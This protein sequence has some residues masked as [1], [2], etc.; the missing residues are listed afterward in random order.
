MT[1]V[2]KEIGDKLD[3][4]WDNEGE[5]DN[6]QRYCRFPLMEERTDKEQGSETY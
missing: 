6:N 1:L 3:P 5:F 4:Y 2:K